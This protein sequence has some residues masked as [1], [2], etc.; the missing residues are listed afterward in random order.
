[1]GPEHDTVVSQHYNG[2]SIHIQ[3]QYHHDMTEKLLT[4]EPFCIKCLTVFSLKKM[5]RIYILLSVNF[6]FFTKNTK[7]IVD[8]SVFVH[9]VLLPVF[10]Y[11]S[12][13]C[14]KQSYSR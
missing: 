11:L 1:M 7:A 3:S 9:T 5:R 14:L 6:F 13:K 10:L 8:D 2:A 12:L 4:E